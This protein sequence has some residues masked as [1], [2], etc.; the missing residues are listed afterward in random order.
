MQSLVNKLTDTTTGELEKFRIIFRWI[1]HNVSYDSVFLNTGTRADQS[2]ATV[3]QT[4][5]AVCEGFT[6]L[7]SEM[8]M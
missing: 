2:P 5:V 1:S 6:E 4:G 8:S 3:L 7:L